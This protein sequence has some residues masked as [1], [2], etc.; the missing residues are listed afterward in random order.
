MEPIE[1]NVT[2]R[3]CSTFVEVCLDQCGWKYSRDPKKF[4]HFSEVFDALGVQF[5]LSRALSGTITI[6]NKPSRVQEL[7]AQLDQHMQTQTLAPQ[8]A[9]SLRGKLLFAESQCFGRWSR[10]FRAE[11]STRANYPYSGSFV[12]SELAAELALLKQ[13]L[14]TSP[15]RTISLA[16]SGSPV[17]LFTDGAVEGRFAGFGG[18]L[19]HS[20]SAPEYFQGSVPEDV[21]Q[22]WARQGS[23][24]PVAH[25]EL[26]PLLV[27][28]LVW[29]DR[30]KSRKVLW[31]VDNNAVLDAL[32]KG[33]SDVTFLKRGLRE[34]SMLERDTPTTSWFSRVPSE[35]NPADAPS[36]GCG[37]LLEST[38][39]AIE[40]S[41][42]NCVDQVWDLARN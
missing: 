36:R 34:F 5:D 17:V 42:A 3:S 14:L 13:L 16:P 29:A 21:L 12:E 40:V 23:S 39:G 24:H 6:S 35:S 30:I 15:P 38:L 11:L 31:F 32:I 37:E 10:W 7:C 18:V 27:S 19:I 22:I 4:K 8:D 41:S 9:S 33:T 1:F 25:C 28:K 20:G 26:V 2:A